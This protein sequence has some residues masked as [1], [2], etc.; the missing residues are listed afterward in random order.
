MTETTRAPVG[1]RLSDAAQE[2]LGATTQAIDSSKHLAS[3]TASRIGDTARDLRDSA[4]DFARTTAESVGET[5]DAAQ[6]RVGKLARAAR[7]RVEDEPL[8]AAL[9]AA[10]LGAAAAALLMAVVRGRRSPD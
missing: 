5:T 6:R 4:A 2:A 9:I 1:A 3:K 8:K 7:R 10:A